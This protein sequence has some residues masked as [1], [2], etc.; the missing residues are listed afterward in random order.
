MNVA[1]YGHILSNT[2]SLREAK[3]AVL[4][5]S[6]IS[7]LAAH[8]WSLFGAHVTV[9]EK[10]ENFGGAWSKFEQEGSQYPISTHIIMP[11]ELPAAILEL[12]GA[13]AR[14]WNMLPVEFD[15]NTQNSSCFPS[16][17]SSE[18]S[19]L[20]FDYTSRSGGLAQDLLSSLS[21]QE[22]GFRY[23]KVDL[24]AELD[25][26]IKITNSRGETS[27]YDYIFVTPAIQSSFEI[28]GKIVDIKYDSHINK[29]VV[30][31]Y[32]TGGCFGSA[33]HHIK[34]NTP[35]REV[36]T[37][38]A[39]T[40]RLAIVVKLSRLGTFEDHEWI[41]E[42]LQKVLGMAL[43]KS[44]LKTLGAVT[45]RNTRM[46]LQSQYNLGS[47]AAR[48]V[49]PTIVSADEARHND[50]HRYRFS[51]DISLVLNDIAFYK[52]LLFR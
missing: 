52:S 29:S 23:E 22:V 5:S 18:Y 3:V 42:T 50:D 45:Y 10:N 24:V 48:I 40:G 32:E 31:E 13:K 39:S 16:K 19:G 7:L 12:F 51:Q 35:V 28:K 6:P 9:Y 47:H 30:Y 46:N 44:A 38:D 43:K 49:L 21:D 25:D 41:R 27:I 36:Q 37:F 4:G 8:I 26:F 33:F 2:A 11:N 17:L 1:G 15:V 34:G 20:P 14:F